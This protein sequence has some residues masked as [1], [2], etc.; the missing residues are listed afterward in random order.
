MVEDIIL[1]GQ[2][3]GDNG[4]A[5]V[6]VNPLRLLEARYTCWKRSLTG[7]G[8]E[9]WE[10]GPVGVGRGGRREGAQ[11]SWRMEFKSVVSKL[12]R[13]ELRTRCI[14]DTIPLMRLRPL[15]SLSSFVKSL[16]PLPDFRE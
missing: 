16:F 5:H 9:R 4:D 8:T 1:S 10:Q 7:S 12:C 15:V 3:T 11:S 14:R 2:N 6:S 13:Q